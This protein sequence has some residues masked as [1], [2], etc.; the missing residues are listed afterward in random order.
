MGA[1]GNAPG[2]LSPNATSPERARQLSRP[3]RACSL[4]KWET[5]GFALGYLI[6]PFQG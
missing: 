5:Q 4:W 1:R 3:F 6:S 2:K